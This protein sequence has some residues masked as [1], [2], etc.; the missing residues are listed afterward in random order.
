MIAAQLN[1]QTVLDMVAT[2]NNRASRSEMQSFMGFEAA[3]ADTN[4]GWMSKWSRVV[5]STLLPEQGPSLAHCARPNVLAVQRIEA[6]PLSPTRDAAVQRRSLSVSMLIRRPFKALHAIW[7]REVGRAD[8]Q[9]QVVS[10]WLARKKNGHNGERVQ[11]K[12]SFSLGSFDGLS[13]M[14]DPMRK[15]RPKQAEIVDR[16]TRI[17]RASNLRRGLGSRQQNAK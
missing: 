7:R 5:V 17:L 3:K 4:T 10:S 13:R 2:A 12:I 8:E 14:R 9:S 16:E 15:R 1:S 11:R 6:T